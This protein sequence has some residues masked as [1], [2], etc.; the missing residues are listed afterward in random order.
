M[1]PR[2][3][4]HIVVIIE[5]SVLF[6]DPRVC[7]VCT[8]ACFPL[9]SLSSIFIQILHA[10][11]VPYKPKTMSLLQHGR[12]DPFGEMNRSHVSVFGILRTIV[13]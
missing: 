7:Q 12:Q 3:V 1:C 5:L 4:N 10:Y 8:N 6:C 9:A 2:Y 11:T 13:G